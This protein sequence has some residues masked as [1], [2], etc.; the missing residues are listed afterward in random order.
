MHLTARKFG[1]EFNP[2]RMR[3]GCSS[4]SVCMCVCY[5][6]SCYI[7]VH[8]LYVANKVP[9]GFYGV[10]K[11]HIVWLSLN[12]LFKSFGDIY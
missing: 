5:H 8:H 2:Q 6:A 9:L 10:F 12:P 1:G 11:I 3:E 7:H 4:C